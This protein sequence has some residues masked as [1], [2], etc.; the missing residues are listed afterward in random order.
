[1]SH[2]GLG[3]ASDGRNGFRVAL[4][5]ATTERVASIL[6]LKVTRILPMGREGDDG[7]SVATAGRDEACGGETYGLNE[8]LRCGSTEQRGRSVERMIS[9]P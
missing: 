8:A 4:L 7:L 3:L 5:G 6:F 2:D 9:C 1:M